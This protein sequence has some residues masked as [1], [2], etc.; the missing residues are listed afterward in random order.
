MDI[1]KYNNCLKEMY[2]L[3]RFGIILGL[4]KIKNILNNLDNPHKRFSAIH[5]AGT[6]GKGSVASGLA[7]ILI[8]AGYCTGL[9]TSPHLIHFNERIQ[10][11]N[12]PISN[13]RVAELYEAVKQAHNKKIQ[14]SEPE[15][16]DREATFFEYT[17]AM[18]F[19]EFACQNVDWAVIETGMGGRFDATNILCPDISI[20]TNIS[21]EHQEYLGNTLEKIAGEKA[22]IIKKACPVISGVSQEKVRRVIEDKAQENS[23][24]LYLLERDFKVKKQ[25][26]ESFTYFGMNT[27][28][29]NMRTSLLGNHQIENAALVLG[30]CEVL[31][32]KG[33]N[34]S[35]QAIKDGLANISWP[36]RL[37]IISESPLIIIDGAHNLKAVKS[38]TEFLAE[39]TLDRDLTL[40]IGILDDKPY[41]DM[42]K[43]LLPLC[44]RLILTRPKIDRGVAAEKLEAFA[45]N[46]ISDI[47]VIPDVAKALRHAV[48]TSKDS[49]A[50]CVAGSLYVVGE[51]KA[52]LAD[53]SDEIFLA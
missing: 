11:N 19:Y 33:V 18:A 31:N 23:A 21:M 32:Q 39:K 7:S 34:I 28:W 41:K 6:N 13:E 10:I 47:T 48:K 29:H 24:P 1:N 42:L 50:I 37:E 52:E 17:T 4:S 5:I 20:I 43:S 8:K 36:G 53:L 46:I 45:K 49:D 3:R 26:N 44:S 35:E 27:T 38:L 15:N 40:I 9:Y 30:A 16:K 22:G 2:G 14:N 25:Q 12:Q 51:A